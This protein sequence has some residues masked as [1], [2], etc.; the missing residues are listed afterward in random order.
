[1]VEARTQPPI[2]AADQSP[3]QPTLATREQPI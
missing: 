2:G 1:M 3:A